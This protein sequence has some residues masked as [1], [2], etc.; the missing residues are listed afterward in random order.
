MR[1]EQSRQTSLTPLC[2]L[3]AESLYVGIDIGKQKHVAGFLSTTLLQRYQRFEACPALAF[4]NSREGFRALVERMRSFVALEQVYVL[5]EYTGHYHKLLEQYLQELDIAVYLVHVHKRA[6]GM[7]KTDKRDALNLANTLYSQLELG[8]QIANKLLLVRRALPPTA[9]ASQL[10]GLIRHRYELMRESTQRKNN[11]TALC[12]EL[13]PEL[14]QVQKDPNLPTAL[15]IR[16][17]FPTPHALATA[18]FSR[19]QEIRG[20]NRSLSDAKLGELQRLASQSI[21]TKNVDRQRSL[22][23]EQSQLIKELRLLQEHITVLE[24]EICQIT[25]QSREGQIL[26]SIPGFG[27]LAAATVIAAI[28]NIANFESAAAFK[29][30]LGWAPKRV[31]SGTSFDRSSLAATGVRPTKHILYLVVCSALRKKDCAWARLYERLLPRMCTYDEAAQAYKG[32]KRVIGRIAGQIAAQVY[33]LLKTDHERLSQLAS[34]EEPPAP[35]LYDPEVHQRHREG[36]Y[37]P[38]KPRRHKQELWQTS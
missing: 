16:E 36:G 8:V 3:G 22:I 30:Y 38:L 35:L 10:R 25:E 17:H 20:T 4:E 5:M 19:L 33:A 26:I 27:P 32:K 13:F 24:T 1:N 34:G 7:L 29:S 9:A 2:G 11:L 31:Q 28:G 12:D 21:G 15:A 6:T 37:Q 18:S 14:T 23:L